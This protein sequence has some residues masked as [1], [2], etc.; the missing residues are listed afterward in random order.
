MGDLHM[1][2]DGLKELYL[3]KSRCLLAH[4]LC[5]NMA[6]DKSLPAYAALPQE[7]FRQRQG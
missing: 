7:T 5:L 4:S 2:V 1:P 3:W 6:V